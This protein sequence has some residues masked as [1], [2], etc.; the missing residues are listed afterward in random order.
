MYFGELPAPGCWG[1]GGDEEED[2][3]CDLQKQDGWHAVFE[4]P[5]FG[6][7]AEE[8]HAENGSDAA[9]QKGRQEQRAF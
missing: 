5:V 4:V 3:G 6:L 8:I 9:A 7:V 1:L 2:H